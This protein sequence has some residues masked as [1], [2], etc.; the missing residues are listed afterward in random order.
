[1]KVIGKV[2]K[3]AGLGYKTANLKID[4]RAGLDKLADGVYLARVNYQNN[5]YSTIAVKGIRPDVEVYLLDFNGDLYGQ[6]LEVEIL[7]KMREL[8]KFDKEEKLLIQIG[9]DI[10]E[11]KKYFNDADRSQT[12][13]TDR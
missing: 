3:G 12:A 5:V 6:I 11:A 1:M 10:K 2:I 9:E 8:I 7:E 4:N 13:Q